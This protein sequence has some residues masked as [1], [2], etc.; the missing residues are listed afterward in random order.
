MNIKIQILIILATL[1]ADPG[2][3]TVLIGRRV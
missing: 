1:I 2:V 3:R